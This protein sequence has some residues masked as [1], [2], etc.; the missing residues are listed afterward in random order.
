M[1]NNTTLYVAGGATAATILGALIY[2]RK[3]KE[4]IPW[5]WEEVG[6]L[7]EID[8]YPLK[9]GHRIELNRA[10]VT[11]LGLRQAPEDQKG[12]LLRDRFLVVYSDKENEFR[13]ARTYPK[14]VLIDVAAHDAEHVS[15]DAPTMRPLYVRI[16]PQKP[17]KEV[18]V[19]LFQGEVVNGID[20][21][22]EAALWLSRYILEKD[23]GLRLAY[24]DCSK[25]R[26]LDKYQSKLM[27]FYK[28]LTNFSGGLYQDLTSVMMVNK[29]SVLDLNERMNNYQVTPKNFRQNLLVEG[30]PAYDEDKWEWVKIGNVVFRSVAECTRCIMTTIDPENGI[31]SSNREPLKTLEQYRASKGPS[32]SPVM[33]VRLEVRKTGRVTVGDKVYVTRKKQ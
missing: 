2:W 23:S 25:R 13:T 11:E 30:P 9:S 6:S 10:D 12:L 21:G 26:E 19:T 5:T 33:G 1:A 27:K 4:I 20:C 17:H 16:P 29:N 18:Q 15:L 7:K 22:D 28:N 24:N 3:R 14:M 32:N 31:R 8:L